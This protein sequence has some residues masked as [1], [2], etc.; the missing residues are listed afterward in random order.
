V[1]R[2]LK[3]ALKSSL[4]LLCLNDTTN[5][6]AVKNTK[7]VVVVS[8]GTTF[9]EARV[10]DIGGIEGAVEKAFPNR[11]FFR[12]NTSYI[13]MKRNAQKGIHVKDLSDTLADLKGH[14]YTDILIQPAHILHG[15]EYEKK[16]L[17]PVAKFENKFSLLVVGNPL[18]FSKEDCAIAASAIATQFPLLQKD[19]GII[20]MGHGSPRDNNKSFGNTYNNLQTS[21]DAMELPV[22]VGTVEEVDSP[23]IDAVLKVLAMRHYKTVHLFPLMIVAGDHA[24]NDMYGNGPES[25]KNKIEKT[26]VKTI[27]H[28]NGIGRNKAIQSLYVQHAIVATSKSNSK[29]I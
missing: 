22:I 11:D 5:R 3:L 15:E 14:G 26:G 23:N 24:H 7:A 12:A 13:V 28:M 4:C 18:I 6:A 20:L 17:E 9:D 27:G 29:T 2:C 25:W 19:E 1:K 10:K 21:S 8:F 16:I